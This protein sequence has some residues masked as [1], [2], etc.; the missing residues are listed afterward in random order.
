MPLNSTT[1]KQ[2][3]FSDPVALLHDAAGLRYVDL[4]FDTDMGPLA[5]LILSPSAV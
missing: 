4:P 5:L 2:F 3:Q 1:A